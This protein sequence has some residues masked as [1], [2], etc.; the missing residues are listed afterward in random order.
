M[1][2]HNRL[3]NFGPSPRAS[4]SDGKSVVLRSYQDTKAF[5]P[6]STCK[7]SPNDQS[8]VIRYANDGN[9]PGYPADSRSLTRK[10]TESLYSTK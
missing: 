6:R 1:P 8:C 4:V 9:P 10:V 3:S 2:H 7:D 5:R